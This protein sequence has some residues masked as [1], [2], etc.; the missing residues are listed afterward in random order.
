[1]AIKE[2][3]D[4]FEVDQG[5]CQ[6]DGLCVA[7]CPK[8]IIELKDESPVPNP[9]AGALKLCMDCGHCVA[10]CPHGALS[11]RAMTP[12]QCPPF[13]RDMLPGPENVEHLMRARRSI[14]VY[15]DKPVEAETLTKLL[16]VASFAPTWANTQKI[17][18]VVV[19][20]KE[21]VERIAGL[22]VDWMRDLMKR[23]DMVDGATVQ[24]SKA[25]MMRIGKTVEAWDAGFDLNLRGA[26]ALVVAHAPN[27]YPAANT[28]CAISLS[29]LELAA[30][31]L[32]LGSCWAGA[33]W[34]VTK[35]CQSLRE[36]LGI[37][38][39]DANYGMM[40]GYS[41]YRYHRLPLRNDARI[42]WI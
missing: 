26:P 30:S 14:R 38:E 22:A 25:Y 41:K 15:K 1:M 39:G 6:R 3:L 12:E 21:K 19:N 5:K 17:K 4:L 18:W 29:Y 28:D 10:I 36:A 31:S 37:P 33:L 34:M 13:V 2:M 42:T 9:I 20:G 40:I 11:H 7:V 24:L 35:N 27:D 8:G 32:G 23:K 16:N